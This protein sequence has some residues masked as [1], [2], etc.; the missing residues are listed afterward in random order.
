MV[1]SCLLRYVV[2]G[3]DDAVQRVVMP[4]LGTQS[5]TVLVMVTCRPVALDLPGPR[6]RFRWGRSGL[7]TRTASARMPPA[8][9]DGSR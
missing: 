5:W 2:Q 9:R 4:G 1:I 3:G 8:P 6:R 7:P